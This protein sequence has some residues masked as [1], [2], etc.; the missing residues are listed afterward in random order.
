MELPRAGG[1][2]R[3]QELHRLAGVTGMGYDRIRKEIRKQT[4]DVP[5]T[6]VTLQRDV[7]T[8]LVY[9][10]RENQDEFPGVSIDRV[11][12]RSYP[13]GSE[14]A[15][16]LGYV[17]QVSSSD[18]K[19]PRYQ[20]VAPGDLVGRGGVEDTYDSVLRGINGDTRVQVD[21]AGQPTGGTLAQRP[22]Q[23]GDDLKLTI[24]NKVQQAGESALSR[25]ACRGHSWR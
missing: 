8:D 2:R 1:K 11:F 14:A 22:P 10:L 4:K 6:P 5:S 13:S 12:V 17:G 16:V 21:A 19:Q 25:R 18:L 24:D 23:A 3:A 20:G 9:Y 7:S 15:Q